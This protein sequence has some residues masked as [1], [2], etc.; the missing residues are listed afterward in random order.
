MTVL[1]SGIGG[2]VTGRRWAVS[3]VVGGMIAVVHLGLVA[4]GRPRTS[5]TPAMY[6][7]SVGRLAVVGLLLFVSLR[8]GIEALPMAAGLVSVYMGLLGG[9]LADHARHH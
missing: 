9:L 7:L 1:T 2:L 6:V 3:S 8:H 4:M 5:A